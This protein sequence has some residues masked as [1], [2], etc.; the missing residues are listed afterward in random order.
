MPWIAI[1]E[2]QKKGAFQ[3]PKETDVECITCGGRMRVWGESINGIPRH[4]KHIG[5]MGHREGGGREACEH[6]SESDEHIKWKN[7]AAGCLMEEFSDNISECVVEMELQA[8]ESDKNRRIGDVV[9]VFDRFDE[10]LGRGIVV[11]VQHKNHS[12]DVKET[13]RDYISQGFSVVWTYESDYSQDHCRLSEVDFRQRAFDEA[14]PNYIPRTDCWWSSEYNFEYQ[15]KEWLSGCKNGADRS[16]V[17]ATLPKEWYDQR[18]RELWESQY[19]YSL[20]TAQSHFGSCRLYESEKYILEVRKSLTDATIEVDMW[21]IYPEEL[22]RSWYEIGFGK[23]EGVKDSIPCSE[24]W[25]G[26]FNLEFDYSSPNVDVTLPLEFFESKYDELK[27]YWQYGAGELKVDVA[28]EMKNGNSN[29]GCSC[30]SESAD[31]YLL[32]GGV[33]SEYRCF[34]CS[35]EVVRSKEDLSKS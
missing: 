11:E 33:L 24:K 34:D 14:W 3:V 32:K 26:D 21:Q 8:P 31:Y 28:K 17:P 7:L 16:C 23:I 25:D 10:K 2:G 15:Q 22:V 19:W 12:K 20:F 30:C 29:R 9:L 13:T 27:I 35:L 1:H 4:F 6:V 18:A 5:N